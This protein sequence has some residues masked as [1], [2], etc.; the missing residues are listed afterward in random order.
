M[1]QEDEYEGL[2]ISKQNRKKVQEAERQ[3]EIYN[4]F[5]LPVHV[6][7]R[8]DLERRAHQL[9]RKAVKRK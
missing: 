1:N 8:K 6:P 5:K 9:E 3:R 4:P 7:K 2:K